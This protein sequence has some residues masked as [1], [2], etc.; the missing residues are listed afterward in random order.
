MRTDNERRKK[1]I[2][3]SLIQALFF[4][5]FAISTYQ[6]VYLQEINISSTDIGLIVNRYTYR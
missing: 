3:F 2:A 6:T 1:Y 5:I 4:A